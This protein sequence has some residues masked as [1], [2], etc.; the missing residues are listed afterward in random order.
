MGL[1]VAEAR[2]VSEQPLDRHLEPEEI[3]A[4]VDG[5]SAGATRS[6]VEAHLAHCAD[7]RA[8]LVGVSRIVAS[9]PR[10]QARRHR[11]W[12]SAAAAAIVL[13]VV[14]PRA[15]RDTSEHRE[16]AVTTTVAPRAVAPV[17]AV[18]SATSLMWSSVPHA[19]RYRVR[20]FTGDGAVLWESETTDTTATL[21]GSIGLRSGGAYFWKVEAQT[22]FGRSAASELNEFSVRYAPRR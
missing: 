11:R 4:Y 20:L 3:S 8:E 1:H 15:S 12:W 5:A 2:V 18:D 7:C 13:I 19:D 9:L 22:G 10:L 17:G 6:R 16:A 21:P 14:T